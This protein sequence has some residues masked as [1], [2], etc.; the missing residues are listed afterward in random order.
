MHVS[1]RLVV[2]MLPEAGRPGGAPGAGDDSS[3]AA[4]VGFA[5]PMTPDHSM[6]VVSH[7]SV[8]P[9]NQSVYVE[10]LRRGWE[11]QLV[12]PSRWRHE[13]QAASFQPTALPELD[14]RL[15]PLR[16]GLEGRPQRHFYVARLGGIIVAQ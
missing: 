3:K 2:L 14:G 5:C 7:P 10:L 16:V 1:H 13:Y 15:L 12:V 6:L 11:V 4:D 8:V 9:I